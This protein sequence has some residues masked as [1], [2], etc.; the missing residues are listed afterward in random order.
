M[1]ALILI[2]SFQSAMLLMLLLAK[3]QKNLSDYCLAGYLVVSAISIILAYFEISNRNNGYPFPWL[4]SISVP[5]ILLVG[6]TLWLYIKSITTEGFRLKGIY[7]LLLLPFFFV[8]FL[9]SLSFFIYSH[10]ARILMEQNSSVTSHWVFLVIVPLIGLSNIGYP[11]WGLFMVRNYRRKLKS[12]FSETEQIDL[13]WLRFLLFSSLVAYAA[14]SGLYAYNAAFQTIDYDTLQV[15]GYSVASLFVLVMGFFG[16]RQG[17]VFTNLQV[18]SDMEKALQQPDDPKLPANN[19]DEAFIRQLLAFMKE[20]KPYLDPG[21]TLGKLSAQ[22]DTTPEFLSGIINGSLNLNFYDFINHYRTEEFKSLCSNPK[23]A[24]YT[25]ISLAFDSGFN[26]KAT[27]NR[28]FK[29][30]V[31][32]TPGEY[33]RKVSAS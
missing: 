12:Y 6:P 8:V 1:I 32:L 29:K 2:G 27:F 16:I 17:N 31:G 24:G 22:L 23:N 14:I 20:S 7:A 3:R 26:S 21:L 4:V 13:S 15:S 18:K 28:V 11:L 9:I 33:F 25:L 5:S 10:E 19:K 30:E